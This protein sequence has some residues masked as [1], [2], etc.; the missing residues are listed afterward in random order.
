LYTTAENAMEKSIEN[1]FNK[2]NAGAEITNFN[3]FF[4]EWMNTN[5]SAFTTLF[6][7]DELS[8]RLVRLPLWVGLLPEMQS[9]L[10]IINRQLLKI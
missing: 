6:A 7:T 4:T 1:N 9:L 5:E 3:Q 10:S 8:E 2:V